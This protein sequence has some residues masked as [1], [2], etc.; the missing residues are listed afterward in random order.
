VDFTPQTLHW[1]CSEFHN[2]C[3]AG[4][5]EGRNVILVDGEILEMPPPNPPHNSG[6]ELTREVLVNAFGAGHWVRVQMALVLS[7]DIDPVPDLAVILGS[8]RTITSQPTG[9]LLVVEVSD[10]TLAYDCGEKM[11]LYADGGIAEYWVLDL[12]G[13]QL[14]VWRDP[15]ADTLSPRGHRYATRVTLRPTDSISPLAAPNASIIVGD[16]L[17]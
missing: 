17:P 4:Y 5:L 7:L 9:A 11:N 12:N 15:V 3:D 1:T 13:R 6:V 10:S 16:L 2:L 14:I 8:P